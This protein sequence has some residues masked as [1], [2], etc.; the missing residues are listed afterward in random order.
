ML[1]PLAGITGLASNVQT[2]V[3]IVPTTVLSVTP[4]NYTSFP[5]ELRKVQINGKVQ[6]EGG[7][8]IGFYIMN[9][10][11][12]S[13]WRQSRPTMVELAQPAAINYNF[14]FVPRYVGRYYLVFSN[15][16]PVRKNVVLTVNAAESLAVV[17]P[18]VQ[19]VH[20]EALLVGFLL[21]LV[22]IKTGKR[23]SKISRESHGP[24]CRFCKHPLASSL[25]FCP[26]CNRS[27]S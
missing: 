8:E 20:Y 25:T 9:E 11:N 7:S 19:Y 24:R 18:F 22:A 2:Q 3:A 26:N 27:Q 6:V 21:C 13:A 16:D 4:S 23:A 15:Q 12:F 17:S 10:G 14:T 5:L 1:Y